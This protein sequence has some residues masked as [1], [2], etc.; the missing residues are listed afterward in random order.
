MDLKYVISG[1]VITLTSTIFILYSV[2]SDAELVLG[3]SLATL[4]VGIVVLTSGLSFREPLTEVL[5]LYV[6]DLNRIISKVLEDSGLLGTHRLRICLNDLKVI[7]SSKV[8][9]CSET[10]LGFGLV[11][12]TPYLALPIDLSRLDITEVVGDDLREFL[13]EVLSRRLKICRS[14]RVFS[15]DDG[16]VIELNRVNEVVYDLLKVPLN[17]L[18]VVTAVLTAKFLGKEVEVVDEGLIGGN[19]V[20]RLR[21]VE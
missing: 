7:L 20:V 15:Y 10:S 12:D 13:G 1:A 16:Y 18:K 3:P 14:V 4:T 8:V 5:K 6:N 9:R 17:Y 19:Y 21:V 2:I 11:S